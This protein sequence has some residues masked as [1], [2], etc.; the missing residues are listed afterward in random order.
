MLILC[1]ESGPSRTN[2]HAL[3]GSI[4][5]ALLSDGHSG[6]RVAYEQLLHHVQS[7]TDL[8]RPRRMRPGSR[9]RECYTG[10]RWQELS[11][12]NLKRQVDL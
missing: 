4:H 8:L 11:S 7:H 9:C 1:P 2:Q 5:A 12:S 3:D 10:D 6:V